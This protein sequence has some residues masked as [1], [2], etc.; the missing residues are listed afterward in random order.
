MNNATRQPRRLVSILALLLCGAL[1]PALLGH[2]PAAHAASDVS[3]GPVADSFVSSSE[4][5]QNFNTSARL[6]ADAKP[7][8]RSF[9]RFVVSG[10]GQNSVSQ[11]RLR[12]YVAEPSADA[13]LKVFRSDA[14]WDEATVTWNTQPALGE[15]VA[16]TLPTALPQDSWVEVDLGQVVSGDGVYSF[17]LT[18]Q[19]NDRVGFLSRSK[20]QGPQ[21]VLTL[22]P[23]SPA[24]GP[25]TPAASPTTAP[26]PT[27]VAAPAEPA[28]SGPAVAFPGAEGF[29]AQ[30]V[31][32][33]GGRVIYV[34]T[35]ADSGPGSLRAALT[36]SGARTVLFQVAGTIT[37]QS[38]IRITQPYLTVVG[39]SAPGEGVQIRGGM[40]LIKTHDV[41][42]RYLRVRAGDAG[43][44]S[45]N[46]TRDAISLSGTGG[47]EVYNV[48]IDHCSLLWGPD[49]GGL[50]ILTNAHDISVQNSIIGEGLYYSNH[51]EAIPPKG[52]SK[53]LNITKLSDSYGGQRPTRIT[54]HHN[55]F[56]SSDD[57]MPQV[58]GAVNVDMVNN[59]IY[60]WGKDAGTGNPVS[61]NMINNMFIAGPMT[62]RFEAW[63][64]N[65]S[66]SDPQL[67]PGG[68]FEQGTVTVG[69]NTV[70]GNPQLAYAAEQFAPFSVRSVQSAQDAYA[71]V[72][73][74]AGAALPARDEVDK[75]IIANLTQRTGRFLNGADLS[76]PP[77]AVGASP[78]D[79]DGDGMPDSWEQSVLGS[80][81][82]GSATDTRGDFDGDGYTDLEEYLN[83]TDPRARN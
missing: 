11:V 55:L 2:L 14:G 23:P 7:Q 57:R 22:S 82:R 71:G 24:P 52:H 25:T 83:G 63:H 64:P 36:A 65:T 4:P 17:A 47:A 56:T 1:T 15:L 68:I 53:G 31:G 13:G 6:N 40:L 16:E 79:T 19:T 73:R 21:L 50:A 20:S 58:I 34:T 62:T 48:M 78:V 30:T 32:G 12:L 39:Q 74:E 44:A 59:V 45:A 49:I 3:F 8:I 60:N 27:A 5:D 77:L 75:R 81:S 33:R 42:L 67:H 29:G 69:F 80:T 9:M 66:S 70:R 26:A 18:T 51:P 38:D 46:E 28:E 43:N 76:W 72:V 41:V 35:L 37:L 54:L 10:T 61:M